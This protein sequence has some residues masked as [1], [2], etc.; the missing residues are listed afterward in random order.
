M[1][2]DPA[3][4]EYDLFISVCVDISTQSHK[5]TCNSWSTGQNVVYSQI[6]LSRRDMDTIFCK[7]KHGAQIIFVISIK[8]WILHIHY[9]DS[10]S[11]IYTSR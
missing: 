2:G 7:K 8:L 1:D 11:T 4:W 5:K 3:V 6:T 9:V 10:K